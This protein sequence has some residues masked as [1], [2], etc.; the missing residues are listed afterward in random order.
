MKAQDILGSPPFIMLAVAIARAMPA[1]FAYWL[2]RTIARGMARRRNHMFSTMRANLAHVVSQASAHELDAMAEA[3]L[4]HA[5]CT[6]FDMF[7]LSLEDYLQGRVA[8]RIDPDEWATVEKTLQDERGTVLVGPHMS[9]FDLA[10]QW[11]AGQG[12]E[13]Q[14]LS[15]A[16]PNGGTRVVN[17]LRRNRGI[18]MTPIDMP[19]LRLAVK[20]LR[21][22]GVILTGVDRSVSEKDEP[23]HFFDAPARLPTGHVRLALQTH[24]RVV[25]ACCVQDPDGCYAVK[26][27]P[28]LE[29]ETTGDR[30]YDLLHNTRRVL[31]IIEDMIRL[32]PEQWLM[33]V[34][35]WRDGDVRQ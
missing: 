10:A 12:Y 18:I 20:R 24:S 16:D 34:P 32:A 29:M 15:L 28:P 27:A 6:Y 17:T 26:L 7:H 1:R 5:G 21:E 3:A 22:G 35:V 4:S 2:S 19:S 25:V 31:A 11:I 14:A 33:F 9:N 23:I 30:A 8:L 13:M